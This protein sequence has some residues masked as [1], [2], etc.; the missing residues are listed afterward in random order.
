MLVVLVVSSSFHPFFVAG[1]SR[2]VLVKIVVVL[3]VVVVQLVIA[4]AEVVVIV[5][6]VVVAVMVIVVIV[7]VVDSTVRVAGFFPPCLRAILAR[8]FFI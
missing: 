8:V 1:A 4:I 3:A 6:T 2:P 5:M 7:I